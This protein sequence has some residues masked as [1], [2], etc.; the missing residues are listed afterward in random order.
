M[1]SRPTATATSAP[2][3]PMRMKKPGLRKYGASTREYGSGL[4]LPGRER[5][6]VIRRAPEKPPPP[7]EKAGRLRRP[8]GCG[9]ECETAVPG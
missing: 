4:R 1:R 6:R 8:G 2:R 5:G 3:P 7:G 9:V